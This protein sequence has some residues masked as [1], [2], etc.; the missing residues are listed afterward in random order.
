M[1]T[2]YI[3]RFGQWFLSDRPGSSRPS[4]RVGKLAA[5]RNAHR[6]HAW[7]DAS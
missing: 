3:R 1:K 5:P 6:T 4:R 2:L 7:R